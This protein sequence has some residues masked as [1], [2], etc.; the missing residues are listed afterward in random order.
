MDKPRIRPVEAFPLEQ[1]GQSVVCLRDPSR[2][3][4]DPIVLGMGAYFLV[5]LFDGTNSVLDLQAAFSRRFGTIIHSEQIRELIAALDRAGYLDS[6]AFAERVRAVREEF[7][8]SPARPAVLAGLCYETEAPRLRAEIESFF[9]RPG[10][11][12]RD[13]LAAAPAPEG[14]LA[15]LVAPH[16]DPRRGAAAYAW[17]YGELRRH[18]RPELVV[19][20]GTSHY[21]AGPELFSATRK[22]YLTPLGAVRTD[23]GFVERLGARYGEAGGGDL[24]ADELLHR[25][26]H[27]IEF[28]ALFLAWALGVG[29]YQVVPVLVGSFHEMVRGGE[30]PA[31]DS[32][33][34]AFLAALRAELARERR[35][36]LILSGVDFAHVGRKFGDP[37]G[38]GNG[39]A[40]RVRRE[41]L[42]L[43]E[44]IKAGDPGGFFAD[45][46]REGD[47]RKICGLAPMYT[48]L[49][50]LRGRRARLLHYDIALEP[51]TDSL[52]SFASLAIE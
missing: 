26:E 42:A 15:G 1:E 8:K 30:Q 18:Q 23:C 46:A 4:P 17:A 33:V 43:I 21:G 29:D 44:N 12:G 34:A 9:E 7:E 27:S 22:D 36:V 11:P 19:I 10:A 49:E 24:F 32:R 2:L 20:L 47:A 48:Q 28:Q 25:N 50:L 45:I 40:E 5:T 38:I 39:V 35:R 37:F 52:V 14:E 13:A 31:N 3:A 6:P 16:I 51:Q 41:D